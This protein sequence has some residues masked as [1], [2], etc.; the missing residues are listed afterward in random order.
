M[1]ESVQKTQHPDDPS[2]PDPIQQVAQEEAAAVQLDDPRITTEKKTYELEEL[3]FKVSKLEQDLKEARDLHKIRKSYIDRMFALIVSWLL[4]VIT[5]VA[6]NAFKIK[7]FILSDSVLIAF[8][9]S[10]TVSVLGIFIIA[11]KW[12]FSTPHKDYEDDM[13]E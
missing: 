11:A 6:L 4:T 9:T 12:L 5:F 13:K 10:T 8:I 7:S 2:S 1:S 3:K